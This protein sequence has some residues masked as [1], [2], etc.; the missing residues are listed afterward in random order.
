MEIEK[1]KSHAKSRLL[2][3]ENEIQQNSVRQLSLDVVVSCLNKFKN[4]FKELTEEEKRSLLRCLVEKV[5]VNVSIH[6]PARG[7]TSANENKV[8]VTIY[9]GCTFDT[10][11]QGL[12]A[13]TSIIWAG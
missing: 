2:E 5:T 1:E 3:I 6:D 9:T 13:P 4:C 12:Q 7:A 10:N 11:G 8:T